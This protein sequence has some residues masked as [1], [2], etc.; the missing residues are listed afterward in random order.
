[1][2]DEPSPAPR[3]GGARES[4]AT[5]PRAPR[6]LVERLGVALI[7]GVMT[8]VFGGMAVASWVSGEGVLAVMAGTGAV[9][10][11][12]AGGNTLLRG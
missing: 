1:M 9:M 12:W 7:A 10:T 3:P 2:S 5:P 8:L 4:A 11:A 6:P